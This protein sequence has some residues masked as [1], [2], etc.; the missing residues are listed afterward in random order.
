M[1]EKGIDQMPD[2]QRDLMSAK[3]RN[4]DENQR[5]LR[6]WVILREYINS[7]EY[8]QQVVNHMMEE[9]NTVK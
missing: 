8:G 6:D 2:V 7:L 3:M 5:P 1:H 9:M 4:I